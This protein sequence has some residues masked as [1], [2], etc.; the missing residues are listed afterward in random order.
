MGRKRRIK[1]SDPDEGYYHV[2]SR[3]IQGEFRFENREKDKFLKLFRWLSDV[4]FVKVGTFSV[5]TNHIHLVIKMI[6]P[7]EI[8]RR[9]LETRF[10]RYYNQS[11]TPE[12]YKRKLSDEEVNNYY[13]RFSNISKFMQDLKQ[14]FSRWY[15]VTHNG[16]GHLWAERFKN[17][18]LEGSDALL[19][20]ML[21]VDLNSVRANMVVEPEKYHYCGLW[22]YLKGGREAQW[23]SHELLKKAISNGILTNDNDLSKNPIK[24]YYTLVYQEGMNEKPGKASIPEKIVKQK[25][26]EKEREFHD[27]PFLHRIRHFSDGIFIGSKDFCDQKFIE[28]KSY[29]K[30]KRIRTAKPMFKANKT[31][32]SKLLEKLHTIRSYSLKLP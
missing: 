26:G 2:M 31:T 13:A 25:I 4:Y 11:G 21:Y 10:N 15:N 24:A 32:T 14:R 23:L 22:H 9:D 28:F 8:S 16:F 29:F 6:N 19:A 7:K 20:C 5:M 18:L 12:K 17:V 1:F 27:S 30:T 3:D